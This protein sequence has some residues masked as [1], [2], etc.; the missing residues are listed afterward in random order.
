MTLYLMNAL[1]YAI[2]RG[3]IVTVTYLLERGCDANL[4]GFIQ[5]DDP[6]IV[7]LTVRIPNPDYSSNSQRPNPPW[8]QT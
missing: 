4:E 7:E 2:S 6:S 5:P 3:D 1:Q 8:G